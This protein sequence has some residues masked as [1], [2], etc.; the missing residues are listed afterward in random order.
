MK[1]AAILLI[2]SLALVMSNA[3]ARPDKGGSLPPGLQKKAARGQALPPGWQKK[4]QKGARL[5][6]EVYDAGQVVV[7][8]DNKG[9]ISIR[10]EDKVIRLLKATREII[11]VTSH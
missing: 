7:P 11:D 8:L 4:L 10:V 3:Q 6:R 2:T 5:D 1:T 9:Y